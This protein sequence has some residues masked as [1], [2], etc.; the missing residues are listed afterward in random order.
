MCWQVIA[1]AGRYHRLSHLHTFWWLSVEGFLG[2]G[3]SNFPLSHRLWSSPLQHSR[4]TVQCECVMVDGGGVCWWRIQG[5]SRVSR[6]PPF[7][8]GALFWKEHILKTCRY[9][10]SRTG[11]SVNQTASEAKMYHISVPGKCSTFGARPPVPL[12]DGLDTRPQWRRQDFVTGGGSEVWVYRG[13]RVRSPPVPAVLSVYQRGSLLDG[14]AMYLSCDTKKFRDNESTHI[15]HN[16]WTSTHRGG[17]FPP[18]VATARP[19]KILDAR[20]CMRVGR[21]DDRDG[22]V[23]APV[24]VEPR[25]QP[26]QLRHIG[27]THL[28]QVC[29]RVVTYWEFCYKNRL[30]VKGHVQ[31]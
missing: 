6:H 8:L 2:G 31:E 22:P 3:G 14:L 27:H 21:A 18:G 30:K 28:A 19:C 9:G 29:A 20:L 24:P 16:F 12:S 17:S 7:C 10:F 1:H 13:S 15:L 5:V 4:T 26:H 23:L 25:H 11:C